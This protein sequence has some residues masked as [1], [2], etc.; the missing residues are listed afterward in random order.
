MSSNDQ[1]RLIVIGGLVVLAGSVAGAVLA[2]PLSLK[3]A[4]LIALGNSIS[5]LVFVKMVAEGKL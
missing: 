3:A 2:G 1:N 4:I 5:G